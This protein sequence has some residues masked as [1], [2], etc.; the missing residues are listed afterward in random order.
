MNTACKTLLIAVA[1]LLLAA[2]ASGSTAQLKHGAAG[3][4]DVDAAYVAAV[5]SASKSAGVRVVWVNPPRNR[6]KD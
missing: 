3:M 2:C 1:S 6:D 5:E 4:N